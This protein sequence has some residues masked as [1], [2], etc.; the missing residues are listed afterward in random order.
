M[1]DGIAPTLRSIF[2]SAPAIPS[3][4][5]LPNFRDWALVMAGSRASLPECRLVFSAT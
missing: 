5:E 4:E 2:S 1:D 3:F